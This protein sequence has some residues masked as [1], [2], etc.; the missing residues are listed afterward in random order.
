MEED[1]NDGALQL[2]NR[3]SGSHQHTLL[4]LF[5]TGADTGSDL[6]ARMA[7]LVE[8]CGAVTMANAAPTALNQQYQRDNFHVVDDVDDGECGCCC[9]C[10]CGGGGGRNNPGTMMRMMKL[11]TENT[12]GTV[13]KQYLNTTFDVHSNS[14]KDLRRLSLY[15]SS[16]LETSTLRIG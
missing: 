8:S 5:T 15:G 9:G 6:C 10:C 3:D 12:L 13:S 16:W 7:V 2:S 14:T 4:L 1:E 11:K